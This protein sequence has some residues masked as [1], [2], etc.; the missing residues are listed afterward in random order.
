[1]NDAQLSSG[2]ATWTVFADS[3][4]LTLL[5]M[6]WVL[7]TPCHTFCLSRNLSKYGVV[8]NPL[9]SL[10]LFSCFFF[11]LYCQALV[12]PQKHNAAGACF[13]S[14]LC[15]LFE[16]SSSS[17]MC[18]CRL[19]KFHHVWNTETGMCLAVVLLGQVVEWSDQQHNSVL[20]LQWGSHHLT[21]LTICHL[22]SWCGITKG[23]L[24]LCP[25]QMTMNPVHMPTAYLGHAGAGNVAVGA[26]HGQFGG[27]WG[28][29]RAHSGWLGGSSRA[30]SGFRQQLHAPPLLGHL[31]THTHLNIRCNAYCVGT[32]ASRGLVGN[33]IGA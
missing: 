27:K 18:I 16:T 28:R 19:G 9:F 5:P 17:S 8:M 3:S 4:R 30:G 23:M 21:S 11:F 12:T 6:F 22:K 20:H 14:S 33:R 1:M 13:A 15:P 31:A 2:Q 10:S 29:M 32:A 26:G 25:V 24:L 7:S